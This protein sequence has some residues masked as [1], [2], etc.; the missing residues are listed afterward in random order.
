VAP[1]RQRLRQKNTP[2]ASARRATRIAAIVTGAS[3]LAIAMDAIIAARTRIDRAR[4]RKP[5]TSRRRNG[6]AT[7][8]PSASR[9]RAVSTGR[10]ND[11]NSDKRKAQASTGNRPHRLHHRQRARNPLRALKAQ[12]AMRHAKN[13]S[14]AAA[15]AVD[16]AAVG[17]VAVMK[18]RK[19]A[20]P[21]QVQ[22]RIKGRT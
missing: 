1:E 7:S 14:A 22:A 17:A 12:Q 20:L 21:A 6:G 13:E 15:A 16:V 2:I 4:G 8:T 11:R 19:V 5:R 18:E 10:S 9:A 3:A